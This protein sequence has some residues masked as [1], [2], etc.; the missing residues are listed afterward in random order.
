MECYHGFHC[1]IGL[2]LLSCFGHV[3]AKTNSV[4][5]CGLDLSS[6]SVWDYPWLPLFL[7]RAVKGGFAA[8]MQWLSPWD[9]LAWLLLMAC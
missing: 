2:L 6:S 5:S 8:G 9:V 4:F 3:R 7:H 1:E